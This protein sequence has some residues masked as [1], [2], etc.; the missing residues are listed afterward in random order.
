[1]ATRKSGP[2]CVGMAAITTGDWWMW[3]KT[4]R[5]LS[6]TCPPLLV[7]IDPTTLRVTLLKIRFTRG[8]S[9]LVLESSADSTKVTCHQ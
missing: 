1:M 6:A 7:H 4:P 8:Q 2:S 5:T 9:R 3:P